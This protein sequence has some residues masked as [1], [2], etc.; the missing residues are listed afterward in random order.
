MSTQLPMIECS[1]CGKII[2]HLYKDFYDAVMTLEKHHDSF[3]KGADGSGLF[4]A[5]RN[6]DIWAKYLKKYYEHLRSDTSVDANLYS[7]KA[8]VAKAL[9]FHRYLQDSDLPLHEHE[10]DSGCVRYCCIRMLM[11]DNSEA[12]Y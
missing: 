5:L 3:L 2:G 10:R 9:L 8:L 4:R 6:E 7:P 1:S 12:P 11:C